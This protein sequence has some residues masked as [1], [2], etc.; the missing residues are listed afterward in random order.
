MFRHFSTLRWWPKNPGHKQPWYSRALYNTVPYSTGS[1]IARLGH[2]SQNSYWPN[3]PGI[4]SGFSTRG[5]TTGNVR[6]DI[7][8]EVLPTVMSDLFPQTFY[9]ITIFKPMVTI[10]VEKKYNFS[11]HHGHIILH[12]RRH[13]YICGYKWFSVPPADQHTP[14]RYH[15][16]ILGCESSVPAAQ[17]NKRE[18]VS[19]IIFHHN[20]YSMKISVCSHS[21]ILIK[22][23]LQDFMYNKKAKVWWLSARL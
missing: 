4:Y 12:N 23:L 10:N 18:Q 11:P 13:S 9:Q 17:L 16:Q 14:G 21:Y 8:S 22:W 7:K 19:L 20:S 2:G 1:N 6:E 5:V 15:S 3:Y